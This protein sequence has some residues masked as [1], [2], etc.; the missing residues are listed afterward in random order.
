MLKGKDVLYR[1]SR[2]TNV[3]LAAGKGPRAKLVALGKGRGRANKEWR[4]RVP[5]ELKIAILI[6]PRPAA[7]LSPV[8]CEWGQES[9]LQLWV[10]CMQFTCFRLQK[11]WIQSPEL[12]LKKKKNPIEIQALSQ[13]CAATSHSPSAVCSVQGRQIGCQPRTALWD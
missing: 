13:P 10:K 6:L 8:S 7:Q 12:Y 1:S 2:E 3:T 11:E 4:A 9:P 5:T